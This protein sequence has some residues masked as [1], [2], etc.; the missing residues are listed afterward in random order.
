M[1]HACT[2][3]FRLT[4][5][6]VFNYCIIWSKASF[7]I[8][9][10]DIQEQNNVLQ[11][12]WLCC[13][14]TSKHLGW[15]AKGGAFII[16][17]WAKSIC[18]DALLFRKSLQKELQFC[19]FQQSILDRLVE[20]KHSVSDSYA[21]DLVPCQI[22]SVGIEYGGLIIIWVNYSFKHYTTYQVFWS[23][24]IPLRLVMYQIV[25]ASQHIYVYI[26]YINIYVCISACKGYETNVL[27]TVDILWRGK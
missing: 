23:F 18:L 24:R 14:N 8:S 5:G 22:V 3:N 6:E 11:I 10:A 27:E 16:W 19:S 7:D 25:K 13:N 9:V 1:I 17:I 2:N 21:S 15:H 4:S 26:L 20:P 12:C